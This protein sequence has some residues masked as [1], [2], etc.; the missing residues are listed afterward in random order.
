[1]PE[2]H[3]PPSTARRLLRR[4]LVVL[5]VAVVLVVLFLGLFLRRQTVS[6]LTKWK[7]PPERTVPWEPH[8]PPPDV[9]LAVAG[10]TGDSGRQLDG[11][12][13][14]VE[15]IGRDEPFDALVLL[16]DNVYPS[17]QVDR[18][19]ETVFEPFAGVLDQGADLLAIL[20]NH[21]VI[22][23]DGS[24]Q[25]E[26]LGMPGRWWSREFG[27]EVLLVGLDSND[28]DD[29]QL[30]FLDEELAAS[31]ATWKIVAL[32]HPPYSAGYQG[33][34]EELR[35]TVVPIL[36]RHGVQ[37]VLSGHDHDYQRSELLDGVTY[38][39]TGAGSGTRRTGEQDFTAVSF[40]WPHFLDLAITGDRLVGRAVGADGTVA[41]EFVLRP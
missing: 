40:S 33:S 11:T 25:M 13:G 7:G 36:E 10:D 12:A 31:D 22:S 35:D 1:V 23:S 20:G 6:Y 30:R 26:A 28:L 24:D 27:D 17:G 39:V 19:D 14:S 8:R 5:G 41:D 34:V 4:T 21:D 15:R 9:H 32:H 2:R 16:G 38:V 3:D 29:R 18:L 37:L